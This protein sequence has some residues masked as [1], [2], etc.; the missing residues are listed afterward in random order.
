MFLRHGYLRI[1]DMF[2]A[3]G[4]ACVDA[5][6]TSTNETTLFQSAILMGGGQAS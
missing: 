5:L 2:K 4:G 3:G 6:L 1:S